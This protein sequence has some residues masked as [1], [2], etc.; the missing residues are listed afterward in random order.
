MCHTARP[1]SLVVLRAPCRPP[2]GRVPDRSASDVR[3]T[4]RIATIAG[5]RA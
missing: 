3:A 5:A 1:S 2:E 4:R